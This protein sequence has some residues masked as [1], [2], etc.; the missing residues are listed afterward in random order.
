MTDLPILY[1]MSGSLYTGKVRSYFRKQR[2]DYVERAVGMPEFR[3]SVVPAI[4]RWII[5]VVKLPGGHL[6]QDGSAI[7]DHFEGLGPS[8]FPALP[9]AG[10][11]RV[12]ALLFE[13]FGGEGLLRPA[14]HYR[15]N[16]DSD[17]EAF[18]ARD[19]AGSLLPLADAQAQAEQIAMTSKRMRKATMIF[20][21][22]PET[23]PAIE[24]SYLDFL[25]RFDAHLE[26]SPYLLGGRPTIG[27]YGLIAALYAHLG[28]DPHPTALMKARAWRVWRWTERMNAPDHDAAEYGDFSE[29][30]FA[31]DAIPDSL[32]HV[33]AYV[34]EDYLPEIVA[35]TAFANDWL[36]ANPVTAGA[37]VT[38]K[39]NVRVMGETSFDWRGQRL[40]VGVF[41]Y[42]LYLLQ[43]IL[44]AA[45]ALDAAARAR[46]DALF[47][48]T[49]LT[50]LLACRPARRVERDNNLEVWGD[51]Q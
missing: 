25:S 31:D 2:I 8:R 33:L 34:A 38:V 29:A 41:P 13:L 3:E 45:D 32:A 17:N 48:R 12:V 20:G 35:M 43:R 37:L 49:G 27:D 16:F 19:F 21:V 4:G 10:V 14:M 51:A 39:P 44:D 50:P 26:H 42:R 18:R 24:A 46:L 15:W 47:A 30:L 11:Q 36:A 7:I 6:V 23:A 40:T 22:N 28:R 9:P 5:P 1:G